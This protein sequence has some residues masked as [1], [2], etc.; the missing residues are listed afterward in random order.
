MTDLHWALLAIAGVVLLALWIYGKWQERRVLTRLH[1]ALRE[2]VG[3]PL[4]EDRAAP[5]TARTAAPTRRIEPRLDAATPAAVGA[6]VGGAREATP[7]IGTDPALPEIASPAGRRR[8]GARCSARRAWRRAARLRAPRRLVR[9]SVARFRHRTT[10]YA[11]DRRCCRARGPRPART[12]AVAARHAPRRVGCES[13]AVDCARSLRL[14]YGTAGGGPDGAPPG[15]A[16]R[17]RRRTIRRSGAADRARRRRRLRC[18]GRAT[19][20]RAGQRAG[21][22]VRTIRC[23]G[24]ADARSRRSQVAVRAC[25]VDGRPRRD[26]PQRVRVDGSSAGQPGTC[27]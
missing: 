10:L 27:C 12:A 18:T 24:H 14:L 16:Q 5:V 20:G 1:T 4:V 25:K 3:D 2:G 23:A 21:P 6:A 13:A 19:A 7:D 11:R 15:R 26:F 17:N 22:V 8:R 9:G